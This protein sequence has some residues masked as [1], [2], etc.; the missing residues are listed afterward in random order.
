MDPLN[1]QQKIQ[2]S[3]NDRVDHVLRKVTRLSN[4]YLALGVL[5][6]TLG[7]AAIVFMFRGRPIL[8]PVAVMSYFQLIVIVAFAKIAYPSVAG[9]FRVA[10][11]SS[12]ETVPAFDELSE[13]VKEIR[14]ISGDQDH[15]IRKNLDKIADNIEALR[16][17]IERDTTPLPTRYRAPQAA[18]SDGPKSP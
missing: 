11:L 6:Y 2:I 14:G 15:P 4:V 13:L 10:L 8:I 1:E 9:A 3:W 7:T 17:R 16:K 12:R 5:A 18:V